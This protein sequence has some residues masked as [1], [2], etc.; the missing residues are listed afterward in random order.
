MASLIIEQISGIEF[1]KYVDKNIFKIC[2]MKCCYPERAPNSKIMKN[3]AVG[4]MLINNN[5]KITPFYRGD[6]L[7]PTGSVVGTCEDLSNLQ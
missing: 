2:K 1:Y 5:F 7:Y 4:Y 3:K 6:W